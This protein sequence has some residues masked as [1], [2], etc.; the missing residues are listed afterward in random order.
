MLEFKTE[1]ENKR[2]SK[3]IFKNLF[4]VNDIRI[5][6]NKEISSE[7]NYRVLGKFCGE[8]VGFG[9]KIEL[10]FH[11]VALTYH[12]SD[13]FLKVVSKKFTVYKYYN[14]T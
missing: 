14:K 3:N 5:K 4:K 7:I 13:A 11:A 8:I 12:D 10:Q 9:R 6:L 1:L 2:I